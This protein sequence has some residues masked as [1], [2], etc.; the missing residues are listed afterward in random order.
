MKTKK[1]IEVWKLEDVKVEDIDMKDY[2][3][4]CDAFIASAT[5]NGIE[6]T[7]EELNE[8]NEDYDYLYS[9]IENTLYE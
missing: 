7:D 1:K 6:L 9:Q 5:L 3:D 4:F 8:V 2:P